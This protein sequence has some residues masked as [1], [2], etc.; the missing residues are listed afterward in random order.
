[1]TYARINALFRGL[2]I[3]EDP[4]KKTVQRKKAA[5]KKAARPKATIV[6]LTPPK[7][8]SD[9][10]KAA[11]KAGSLRGRFLASK[12]LQNAAIQRRRT[13]L[14]LKARQTAPV[15]PIKLAR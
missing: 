14:R 8:I 4:P 9:P 5:P 6:T 2:G 13:A 15:L 12:A 7:T 10:P 11:P 1:M 3:A